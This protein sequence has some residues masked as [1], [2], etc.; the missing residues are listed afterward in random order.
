MED[1]NWKST[2]EIP[3]GVKV[4]SI[5]Y[6]ICSI[7]VLGV[8]IISFFYSL[9]GVTD[10]SNDNYS[11]IVLTMFIFL[12]FS[13]ILSFLLFITGRWLWKGK[14][15]GRTTS[16]GISIIAIIITLFLVIALSILSKQFSNPSN[17]HLIGQYL[18]NLLYIFN[19][20]KFIPKSIIFI[21]IN[22]SLI[23]YLLFNK[24]VKEAFKEI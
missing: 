3:L 7:G 13:L 11:L 9:A 16:V 21:I 19:M 4:I 6:Y 17:E 1:V 5:I 18:S 2:K 23:G 10:G 24:K 20:K 12:C 8:L 14:N 15:A 22:L